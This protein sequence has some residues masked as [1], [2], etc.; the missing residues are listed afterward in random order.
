M[1]DDVIVK[2]GEVLRSIGIPCASPENVKNVLSGVCVIGENPTWY[3]F[4]I[5]IADAYLKIIMLAPYA[6]EI[7]H[8]GIDGKFYERLAD[9]NMKVLNGNFN[10]DSSVKRL[11]YKWVLPVDSVRLDDKEMVKGLVLLPAAMII[12]YKDFLVNKS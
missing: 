3:H 12:K 11:M 1:T 4:M 10:Y 2:I 6:E 7:Q 5:S 8:D 9:V